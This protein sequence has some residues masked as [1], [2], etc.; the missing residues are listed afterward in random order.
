[1]TINEYIRQACLTE[2][3]PSE[4]IKQRMTSDKMT[5]LLHAA[6]GLTTESGEFIDALKKHIFYGRDLDE[7]NLK[8]EMGDLFWYLAIACDALDVSFDALM[9]RNIE[10][11]RSRYGEKFSND[12]ANHR[13]LEKEHEIL[14][15]E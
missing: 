14:A 10:K 9:E 7:V 6:I 12:K 3:K 15:K 2:S 13:D 4:E 5:R 11:L 1:M 8:E